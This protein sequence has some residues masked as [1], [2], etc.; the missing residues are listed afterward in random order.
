[1]IEVVCAFV[2]KDAARGQFELAYGPG[3]AW[4]K[5]LAGGPGYRGTMLLRDTSDPRR[6]LAIELWDS[7]AQRAE[8]LA[9]C[10]AERAGLDAEMEPW[11]AS[12][13]EVGVYRVLAEATVPARGRGRRDRAR[14][15][16]QRSR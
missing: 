9:Q 16:R 13:T 10:A 14:G 7:E 11:I 3:G 5:L 1:M 8:V 4:S 15:A 6:Y 12:R 2:V